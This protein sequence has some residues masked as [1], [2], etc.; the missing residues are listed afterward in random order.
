[1]RIANVGA[2]QS[3]APEWRAH[4]LHN[5]FEKE[6]VRMLSK[7]S[8]GSASLLLFTALLATGCTAARREAFIQDK[9]RDHVYRKPIAEVWPQVRMLLKEEGFSLIEAPGGYEITTEWLQ[10]GA[11]SSLGTTYSRYLARGRQPNPGMT[12]VEF[13]RQNRTETASAP[14]PTRMPAESAGG[15]GNTN[16]R[17]DLELEWKLMQ[18][19]DPETANSLKAESEKI[20]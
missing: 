6:S 19:V 5:T 15:P 20:Q 11:P 18:R 1:M 13:L 3:L 8:I 10:M 16:L 17:R 2:G 9:T 7:R 12:Q 14:T 4:P